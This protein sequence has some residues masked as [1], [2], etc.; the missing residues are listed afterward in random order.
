MDRKCPFSAPLITQQFACPRAHEVVRRGGSEFDC[1]DDGRHARCVKLFDHLK[2]A[3]L[4]AF[5]VEDD[6][7]SMPHSVLVKIQSG[8]LL[9]IQR[10]ISGNTSDR[11]DDI[12]ALVSAA[13]DRFGG[14]FPAEA[15]VDDITAF[16]L[17]ARRR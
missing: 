8:G 4:P 15:F 2:A 14:S 16:K 17:R 1:D 9:G 11:V 13:M 6:L 7:L 10:E 12:D 3:A 5:G